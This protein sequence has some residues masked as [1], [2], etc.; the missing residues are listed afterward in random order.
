MISEPFAIPWAAAALN[1]AIA[2]TIAAAQA[3]AI[4]LNLVTSA[5]SL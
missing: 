1:G 3:N 5:L 4:F 2:Q